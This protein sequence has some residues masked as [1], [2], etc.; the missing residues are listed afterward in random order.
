MHDESVFACVEKRA[1]YEFCRLVASPCL[2][3]RGDFMIS[4][5]VDNGIESRAEEYCAVLVRRGRKESTAKAVRNAVR[6]C[7]EWLEAHGVRRIEDVDAEAVAMMA[8]GLTGKESTRRQLVSGFAGYMRWATGR[9]VVAQARLLWNPQGGESRTWITKDEY[10]RMMDASEPR[11]RLI[12]ALGATMGLRRA[13]MCALTLEDVRGGVV[14]IRG[15]GHGPDGKAAEKPMSEAVRRE[16]AE[17]LPERPPSGS[18][19]LLLSCR[20][21]GLDVNAVYWIVK[22]AGESASVEVSPHT[23]RRLYATTL[24]D[25]GVPLETIARMMR[26]ENPATTMRCYLK[27]DPRR[28]AD[29]QKRVDELLAFRASG[30]IIYHASHQGYAD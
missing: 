14:R 5:R 19:A 15:K 20:G 24:A 27:A 8:Q 16:L 11:D 13:E 28:M 4:C 1:R 30:G 10:R 26:H 2:R 9:D 17:Y 3:N 7:A 22:R 18:D 12:L 21:R 23:L 6:R 29:A 25:A